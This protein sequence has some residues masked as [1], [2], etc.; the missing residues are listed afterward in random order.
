MTYGQNNPGVPGQPPQGGYGQPQGYGQ[1][2]PQGYGQPQH[3]GAYAPAA[4]GAGSPLLAPTGPS[5]QRRTI[6][7][8]VAALS[9]LLLIVFSFLSWATASEEE[10]L[11]G[12]GEVSYSASISGM[13]S[14]DMDVSM[15]S[16]LQGYMSEDQLKEQMNDSA[17]TKMPGIWT[18]IFG[19]IVG[20]GAALVFV[21]KFPGIG[22]VLIA[23]GGFAATIAS[24]VFIAD[25]I[26]AVAKDT[27]SKD[28]EVF[29][30][31]YGLW[32]VLVGSLLALLAGAAM[33][34]LTLAPSKFD[35][36]PAAPVGFGGPG[37][38]YPGQQYPGQQHPGQQAQY[39]GQQYPGQPGPQ[40][41]GQQ[42][43]GQ[44]R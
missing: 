23:V 10:A 27:S 7:G 34:A 1:Q 30:A 19:V 44:P 28:S 15:P 20:I 18:V 29:S 25:P 24:I 42:Y 35:D 11:P 12:G 43:P 8:G 4:T 17:D 40:S 3:P 6:V 39:P 2:P 22:G 36:T 41:P 13:G 14:V 38:Q 26:G 16:E 21:R 32:L 5:T 37:P 31:G 9:A 33:L